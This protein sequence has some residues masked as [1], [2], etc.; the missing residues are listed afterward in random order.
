MRTQREPTVGVPA[1]RAGARGG[2]AYRSTT[3]R[4]PDGRW[5]LNIADAVAARPGS[6]GASY[7]TGIQLPLDA[8]FCVR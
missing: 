3:N 1:P 4:C 2:N 7:I 8:G 6:D 5:G